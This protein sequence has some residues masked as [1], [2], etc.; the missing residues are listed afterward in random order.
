MELVGICGYQSNMAFIRKRIQKTENVKKGQVV[1]N[2]FYEL[3][4]FNI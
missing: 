2:K 1:E 3:C 4:P